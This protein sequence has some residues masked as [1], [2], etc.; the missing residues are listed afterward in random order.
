MIGP[1]AEATCPA[2]KFE[3]THP[4]RHSFARLQV[5]VS[6]ETDRRNGNFT[7]SQDFAK[8]PVLVRDIVAA[9][10]RATGSTFRQLALDARPTLPQ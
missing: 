4:I 1:F 3:D 6:A 10:N 8:G 9:Q 5:V 7:S 2:L